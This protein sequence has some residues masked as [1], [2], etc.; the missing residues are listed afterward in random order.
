MKKNRKAIDAIS[1]K[2]DLSQLQ[3]MMQ[4]KTPKERE[5]MTQAVISNCAFK[6][7]L[8]DN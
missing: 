2:S 7:K 8:A 1:I 5:R 4:E 3:R 6:L